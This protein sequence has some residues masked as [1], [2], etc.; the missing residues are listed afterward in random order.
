MIQEESF[1]RRS[2]VAHVA[3]RLKPSAVPW[4]RPSVVPVVIVLLISLALP[5]IADLTPFGKF[6]LHLMILFF[7]WGIVVEGWNLIMGVSGIFS[8][9][10]VALF[11]VGAWTSGVIT[12]QLGWSPFVAMW[13]GPVAATVVAVILGLPTLR[14]RGA[15]VV[16]LTLG[17]Q[18]LFRNFTT[19]GPNFVAG[20]GYGLRYV[21][22]FPFEGWV[23]G[24][25]AQFL[26]YYL[27]LV[28][29]VIATFAIW[30]IFYSPIGMA[31]R[32]LRDSEVY[33]ISR[34]VSP[35]RYKLF[36]FGFVAF[37]TGWAGA[38]YVHWYGAISPAI[39]LFGTTI[40]LLAMIV[41]GGWGSFWGPIA[42]CAVLTVL[43]E[44]M[45]AVEQY[46][47][48]LLGIVLA[49]VAIFAPEGL[50]PLLL[51]WVRRLLGRKG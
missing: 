45:R 10:Q 23:G 42:G 7:L 24:D 38:F 4:S 13:F 12:Q 36:L 17:F 51:R 48:L 3:E 37:F 8:F 22:K 46:R 15:Y 32:A 16:L 33:A 39:M 28:F 43:P 44:V 1:S 21:P 5:W 31:F 11:A 26:Y 35:F 30:R 2:A 9:A 47:I 49:L 29:F 25:K 18:E 40:N 41:I 34:G 27:A 14:L 19:Q 20:G 50:F 6:V